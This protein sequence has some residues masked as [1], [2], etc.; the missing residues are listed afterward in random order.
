MEGIG[1]SEQNG[2]G[3]EYSRLSCVATRLC[4]PQA[5][6]TQAMLAQ[7]HDNSR[8]FSHQPH[9]LPNRRRARITDQAQQVVRRR[10]IGGGCGRT[11]AQAA[12]ELGVT[13]SRISDLLRGKREKFS[14]ELVTLAGRAGR[15]FKL[16][17]AA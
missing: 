3:W 14:L 9:N 16:R 12:G 2:R 13:Q 5:F 4:G 1:S 10:R 15:T 17:L 8:Q 6:R 11:Q 7:Q